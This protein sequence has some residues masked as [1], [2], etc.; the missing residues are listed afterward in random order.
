MFGWFKNKKPK[1]NV[2]D[3]VTCIDDREWNRSSNGLGAHH[4]G[5]FLLRYG[6]TYKIL[7]IQ[8]SCC[9]YVFDIGCKFI[10]KGLHTVCGDGTRKQIAGAGIHWAG[11]H[12]F[13]KPTEEEEKNFN[14]ESVEVEI[15]HVNIDE[16]LQETGL[17]LTEKK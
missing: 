16:L 11:T 3:L 7:D 14:E 9:G 4:V 13:R 10:D 5:G 6:K 15:E 1:F 17:E 8:K 12:R 2:G